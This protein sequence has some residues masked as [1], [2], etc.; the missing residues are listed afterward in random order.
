MNLLLV[1]IK[2]G[3]EG[4]LVHDDYPKIDNSKGEEY[5]YLVPE[6]L[7]LPYAND[8]KD[9]LHRLFEERYKT[10]YLDC[11]NLKKCDTTG[12]SSIISYQ[13]Y[14]KD[15]GGEIRLINVADEHIKQVFR[16]IQ[17]SKT[18]SVEEI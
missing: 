1:F 11:K 18:L 16:A 17:L 15:R 2:P 13:K 14:F 6:R 12:L 7:V 5:V 9:V 4:W 10:V 3:G 8:F